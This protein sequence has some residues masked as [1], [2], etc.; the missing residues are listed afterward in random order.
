M[1]CAASLINH[2]ATFVLTTRT[3]LFPASFQQH[4]VLP[5]TLH[6][7]APR[8]FTSTSSTPTPLQNSSCNIQSFQ[9]GRILPS[10]FRTCRHRFQLR[11]IFQRR[12]PQQ[13][14]LRH[15]SYGNWNA[16]WSSPQWRRSAIRPH[17]WWTWPWWTSS[18]RCSSSST[19]T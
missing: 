6:S 9:D 14:P 10:R 18:Q 15:A 1:S 5:F 12:T 2:P 13:P 7:L 19:R 4:C 8:A 17:A 11:S 3:F 16:F